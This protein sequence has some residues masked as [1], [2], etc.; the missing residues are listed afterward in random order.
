MTCFM[1]RCIH[2]VHK[3]T[4]N[5]I[6]IDSAGSIQTADYASDLKGWK[7]SSDFNGFAEFEN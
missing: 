1:T 4:G 5:N 2:N 7:I 6:V 3:I